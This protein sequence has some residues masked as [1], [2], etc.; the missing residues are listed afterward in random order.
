MCA[1]DS[2]IILGASP[3]R[4]RDSLALLLRGVPGVDELRIVAD[5]GT[6]LSAVREAGPAL[7]VVETALDPQRVWLLPPLLATGNRPVKLL[8]I[9]DNSS[10]RQR[11]R[12]AGADAVLLRGFTTKDLH[13]TVAR[14][15]AQK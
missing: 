1:N 15:T 13:K 14:L 3:G 10:E 7:L 4:R 8:L 2:L 11:A 9:T 6:L 12:R 5:F